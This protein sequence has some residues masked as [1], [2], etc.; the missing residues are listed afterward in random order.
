MIK[1]KDVDQFLRQSD[2][3]QRDAKKRV[4]IQEVQA[5]YSR[6]I[7]KNLQENQGKE[8]ENYQAIRETLVCKEAPR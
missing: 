4:E 8:A 7:S 1:I 3:H 2:A 6:P 5:P